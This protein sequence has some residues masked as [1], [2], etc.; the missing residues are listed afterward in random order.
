MLKEI[1]REITVSVITAVPQRFR[2]L[3]YTKGKSWKNLM[4]AVTHSYRQVLIT[5]AEPPPLSFKRHVI[6]SDQG[7]NNMLSA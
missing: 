2:T 4:L 3:S 7:I 6:R 5:T 1:R